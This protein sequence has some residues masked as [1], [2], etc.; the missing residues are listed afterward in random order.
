MLPVLQS[1][2]SV[3]AARA[4]VTVINTADAGRL[5][6]ST[7]GLLSSP[8]TPLVRGNDCVMINKHRAKVRG[9]DCIMSTAL[10]QLSLIVSS[11]VSSSTAQPRCNSSVWLSTAQ[12]YGNSSIWSS[13]V[14]S[15]RQQLSPTVTAQCG[16]QQLRLVV[17]SS[18]SSSTG[19]PRRQ[20]LSP[21]TVQPYSLV[22]NSS[23]WS[24]TA[25]SGHQQL[26]SLIHI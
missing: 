1:Q 20:Q 2:G 22:V 14:Q 17:N 5:F 11:S 16:C 10:Q 26:L 15:G 9:N 19:Q 24:S 4:A 6:G 3:N 18:V 23:V 8:A 21:A 25:Q 12:S 13:T 7:V